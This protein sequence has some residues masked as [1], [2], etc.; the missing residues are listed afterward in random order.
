MGGGDKS[1][2]SEMW[3]TCRLNGRPDYFG[4]VSAGE[5]R[6]MIDDLLVLCGFHAPNLVRV[7]VNPIVISAPCVRS[8]V[9]RRFPIKHQLIIYVCHGEDKQVSAHVQLPTRFAFLAADLFVRKRILLCNIQLGL[10]FS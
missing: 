1:I 5:E 6:A 4:Q 7:T 2:Q 10:T 9:F 3:H 8:I